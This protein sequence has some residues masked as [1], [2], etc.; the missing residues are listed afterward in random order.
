MKLLLLLEVRVEDVVVDLLGGLSNRVEDL[1]SGE[2]IS[3]EEET[4]VSDEEVA[5]LQLLPCLL[6]VAV[7][8]Q[9]LCLFLERLYE[10][11]EAIGPLIAQVVLER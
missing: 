2:A 1:Q 6:V 5:D 11:K 10:S 8:R 3:A 4:D 7:L 9:F